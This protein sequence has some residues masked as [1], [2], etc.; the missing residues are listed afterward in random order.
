MLGLRR[1]ID[2]TS[3]GKFYVFV[4]LCCGSKIYQRIYNTRYHSRIT[5]KILF[6]KSINLPLFLTFVDYKKT[7]DSIDWIMQ[8]ELDMPQIDEK[9]IKYKMKLRNGLPDIYSMTTG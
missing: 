9:Y 8:N 3:F 6:K 1:T 2:Y 4:S 5:T 7:F